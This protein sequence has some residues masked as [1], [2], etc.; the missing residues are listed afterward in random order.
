M[1]T[2]MYGIMKKIQSCKKRTIRERS[3]T[4]IV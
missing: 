4:F 1:G 3:V 2:M